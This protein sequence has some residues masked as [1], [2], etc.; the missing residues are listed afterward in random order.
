[1]ASD[2]DPYRTLGLARSATLA[3]VKRAYRRLAK[4]NHPDAVGG[5][6]LPRFLAI[7]SAYDQLAGPDGSGDGIGGPVRGT[8]A[9]RPAARPAGGGPARGSART[10]GPDGAGATHRAYG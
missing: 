5:G 6:A 8:G 10:S 1:M 2:A 4:A 7:Q 9:D 3:E